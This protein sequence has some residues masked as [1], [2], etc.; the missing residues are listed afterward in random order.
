MGGVGTGSTS[1][2]NR[3]VGASGFA[4]VTRTGWFTDERGDTKRPGFVGRITCFFVV[5]SLVKS[6]VGGDGQ[7][8][9]RRRAGSL[10]PPLRDGDVH[11]VRLTPRARRAPLDAADTEARYVGWSRLRRQTR[12]RA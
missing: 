1:L 9:H 8:G 11:I 12:S 10:H 3:R 6:G 7:V 2:R 4:R 5:F